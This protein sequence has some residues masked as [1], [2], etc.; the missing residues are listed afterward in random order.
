[1]NQPVRPDS[2]DGVALAEAKARLAQYGYNEL[3]NRS[4]KNGLGDVQ[5]LIRHPEAVAPVT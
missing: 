1:M 3:P 4:E 2:R 5:G